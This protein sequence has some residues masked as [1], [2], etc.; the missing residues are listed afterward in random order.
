MFRKIIQNNIIKQSS[1]INIPKKKSFNEPHKLSISLI[2]NTT[3]SEFID[4]PA[5][6]KKLKHFFE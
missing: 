2:E 5:T 4:R 3:V 6:P 1:P